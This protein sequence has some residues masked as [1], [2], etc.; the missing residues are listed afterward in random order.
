MDKHSPTRMRTRL[1]LHVEQVHK[2]NFA[3]AMPRSTLHCQSI[4][5]VF[6]LGHCHKIFVPY[7]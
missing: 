4:V 3:L 1:N 5:S 7:L 2:V 6:P